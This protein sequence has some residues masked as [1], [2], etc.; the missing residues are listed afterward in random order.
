MFFVFVFVFVFLVNDNYLVE[1][2]D[3]RLKCTI[4]FIHFSFSEMFLL[5]LFGQ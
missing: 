2:N 3:N 4:Q 5:C 1:I